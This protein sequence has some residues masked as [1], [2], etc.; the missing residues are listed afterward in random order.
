MIAKSYER[1]LSIHAT[2]KGFAYV[3]MNAPG[4]LLDFGI[5]HVS[6]GDKNGECVAL[7]ERLIIR[8]DPHAIVFEDTDEVGARRSSR[9][10]RL[11]RDIEK[12]ADRA[13]LDS[14]CYPWQTVF[15]VF[16][17]SAPHT[18]HDIAKV[19]AEI[20][21]AIKRR[22]PP[23]RKPWLPLDPRQAL[24]DAAALGITHYAV[25]G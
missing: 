15:D 10:K 16:R 1:I 23:K 21:P 19:L 13:S 3:I 8:H 2:V 18:R 14:Y 11:L 4:E 9:V 25:N 17:D 22:L 20:L 5:K 6:K 24:F 12:L 7:V